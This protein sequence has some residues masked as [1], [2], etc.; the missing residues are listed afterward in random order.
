[1]GDEKITTESP[2]QRMWYIW[3]KGYQ[4]E[5]ARKIPKQGI[6]GSISYKTRWVLKK[7]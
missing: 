2:I 3:F 4:I 7:K 5:L 1:M 6:G